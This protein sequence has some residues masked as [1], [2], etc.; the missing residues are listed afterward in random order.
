MKKLCCTR[1]PVV[2]L[3]G[4]GLAACGNAPSDAASEDTTL[5]VRY[6]EEVYAS[7]GHYVSTPFTCT[8]GTGDMLSYCIQNNAASDCTV[9]LYKKG[10]LGDT[11]VSAITVSPDDPEGKTGEF[12]H[13]RGDTFYFKLQASDGGTIGGSLTA[14]Q[15]NLE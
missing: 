3:L 8:E 13:P 15:T 5:S 14:C 10:L 11:L 1:L 9:R 2:L 7:N 6:K 4:I 12:P